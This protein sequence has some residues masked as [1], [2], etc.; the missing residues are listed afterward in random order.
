MVNRLTIILYNSMRRNVLVCGYRGGIGVIDMDCG[1]VHFVD[2]GM[3]VPVVG[4]MY[5]GCE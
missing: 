4:G 3:D 5:T 1:V 2:I